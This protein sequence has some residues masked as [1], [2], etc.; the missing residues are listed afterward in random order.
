[1]GCYGSTIKTSKVLAN[2]P[3][4]DKYSEI[5][6]AVLPSKSAQNQC[7]STFLSVRNECMQHSNMSSPVKQLSQLGVI[8]ETYLKKI[9][10]RFITQR[11]VS[12]FMMK[13]LGRSIQ[14]ILNH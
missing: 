8:S 6:N 12:S 14:I 9:V 5:S 10:Y 7:S 1:M 4:C 3:I 11:K 13:F 2:T